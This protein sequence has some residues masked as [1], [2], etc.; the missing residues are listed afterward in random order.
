[1]L[2]KTLI[3]TAATGGVLLGPALAGDAGLYGKGDP[4]YDGVYRQSLSIL[5]LKATGEKVPRSAVRWLTKQQCADGG[6][7]AYRADTT[8]ACQ[9]A[10]A[11][12]FAGQ[13]TNSTAL[14]V[15][16][17]HHSGQKAKARKAARWLATKRNSDGG[18]AY[19][20]APGATSDASST[21]LALAAQRLVGRKASDAHLRSLQIRCDAPKGQRG[22]LPVD[23]SLTDANDGATAQTAYLLGGG[24]TLAQTT[25]PAATTPGLVCK[26]PNNEKA[27]VTRAARG[28]LAARILAV[29]GALPYGGGFPGTDYAASATAVLALADA[30]VGR[31]PVRTGTRFLARAAQDWITGNGDDAPGALALLMLVADATRNSPTDFGGIDLVTRLAATRQ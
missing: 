18:Y 21:A 17:L 9:P 6:F 31:K 23:A 27:S 3:A 29:K 19:Y 24:L 20:P 12:N 7:Q 2:T 11:V 30:G 22:G 28:Y 14:A 13:D 10:D 5:A 25:R 16:A 1:M 8:T 26:G 4:T 15:A